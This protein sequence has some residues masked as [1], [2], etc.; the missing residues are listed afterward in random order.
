MGKGDGTEGGN[1]EGGGELRER[2]GDGKWGIE[3]L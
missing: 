1:G 2:N 3:G